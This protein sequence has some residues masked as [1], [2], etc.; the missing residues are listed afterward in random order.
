MK[1]LTIS[2]VLAMAILTACSA[3][4]RAQFSRDIDHA[5]DQFVSDT[6]GLGHS[7][8]K[9]AHNVVSGTKKAAHNVGKELDKM[10]DEIHDDLY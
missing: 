5:G 3:S 6:K 10:G 8:K 2:A 7:I 1:L 4:K 9:G